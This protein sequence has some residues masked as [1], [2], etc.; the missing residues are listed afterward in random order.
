[1]LFF[2]PRDALVIDKAGTTGEAAHL[3][4]LSPVGSEFE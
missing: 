2:I 3:A 1:M 4:S